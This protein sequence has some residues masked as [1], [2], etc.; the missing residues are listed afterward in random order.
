MT[1]AHC[2]CNAYEIGSTE[3]VRKY[4][5]GDSVVGTWWCVH[6][7]SWCGSLPCDSGA[8]RSSRAG[9]ARPDFVRV[10]QDLVR[11]WERRTGGIIAGRERAELEDALRAAYEAGA[12]ALARSPEAGAPGTEEGEKP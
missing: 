9:D 10:A 11:E 8:A 5:Q 12:A 3:G 7:A 2:Q 1:A 4:Q 6:T